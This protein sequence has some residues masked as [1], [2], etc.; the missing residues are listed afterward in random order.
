MLRAILIGSILIAAGGL[1]GQGFLIP[2]T[3]RRDMV[4]DFAGHNLYIST[5]TGLIKTF[6][7]S[8]RTFGT[9]YNLGGSLWGIDIA[10][11][12]SFILAAQGN[13]GASQGTIQR[14]DLATGAITNINYTR[15]FGE[16][17]ARDVAIGSNGLALVTTQYDGSGWTPLRQI[18]LRTNA[19][20]IRTDAPGSGGG[21][22][23]SAP[24]QIH[25][26]ADGTRFFFMEGNISSGPVFTYDAST[27]TFGPSFE[28]NG[29]LD[30]ASGA[31]NR[32]GDLIG[33]RLNGPQPASLNTAPDFDFLHSFNGLN[34]G[35]AFDARR[36]VF[37]GVNSETDEI[38]GY[39]TNT[40]AELF[41]VPVGEDIPDIPLATQFR[42]GTLVASADG[43]WLALE[44]DSGIRVYDV[45]ISNTLVQYLDNNVSI[46]SAPGPNIPS[47]WE[48]VAVA[49]FNGN[50]H[51]DYLLFNS[52]THATSIWYMNN[53]V[54]VGGASGR[55][56][57]GGWQVVAAADFNGD[58]HPDYLL[59]NS[60]THDTVIWYLVGATFVASQHGPHIVSGW[61]IVGTGD[62]NGDGKPDLVL[63]RPSTHQT[64]IW[65]MNNNVHVRSTSGPTLPG[66]W[67]LVA[68]ADF[69][70]SGHPDYLLFRPSTGQSVIWYLSGA[71]H[72][73]SR[74]G[75]TLQ[76]GWSVAGVAD[77]NGDGHPDYLLFNADL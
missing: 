26:S 19:I 15:A 27:N 71:T 57:P 77:F 42:T 44:T 55:T 59:F 61:E 62:F 6:H 17:G 56:V 33:L 3:T 45:Q 1:H 54:R 75:P 63:Y 29:Y 67:N 18:D 10:R 65:Y 74:S 47:G 13:V 9:T 66:G 36:D 25:R 30:S 40:F 70:G 49:D 2:D 16:D 72:T 48:I 53:N 38:I 5:S 21:G 43:R 76:A 14:V 7:L 11:N 12:N 37:Y 35:V 64:V 24:T 39:S 73:S 34:S 46:G 51:P 23:V 4:F 22:Q 28:G 60:N 68:V 31:V 32:N 50:G 41:R 58:G 69:N 52:T 8:T 20:T